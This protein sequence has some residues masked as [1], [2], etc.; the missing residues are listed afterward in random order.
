M[1]SSFLQEILQN[2]VKTEV[3]HSYVSIRCVVWM[4]DKEG[5]YFESVII[6]FT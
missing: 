2:L 5:L 6:L 4:T 1:A 3:F